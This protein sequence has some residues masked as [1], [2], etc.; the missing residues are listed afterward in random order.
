MRR[1]TIRLAIAAAM[2]ALAGV[3]VIAAQPASAQTSKP[4][5][6]KTPATS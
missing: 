4:A 2:V 5:I 1:T 3:K 6:V